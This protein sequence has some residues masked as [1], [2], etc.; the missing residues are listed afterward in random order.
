MA[1]LL[2]DIGATQTRL[3][4]SFDGK[5]VGRKTKSST[6]ENFD[7][8]IR[9]IGERA[10]KLLRGVKIKVV[11]G[12]IAGPL[13][14]DKT[15]VVSEG[16][17][18]GWAYRPLRKNLEELFGVPT[19][20]ENDTALV[21]LGESS[22]GAGMG[23]S[24][25]V[26]VTLSSGFGAT[27][28]VNRNIDT[29]TYGFE[30]AFQVVGYADGEDIGKPHHYLKYHISGNRLKA[31]YGKE[32]K[33]IDDARIWDQIARWVAVSMNNIIVFWSPECIVL[34]GSMARRIHLSHI[35]KYV[36]QAVTVFPTLPDFRRAKLGNYGGLYGAL[37]LATTARYPQAVFLL[38]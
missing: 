30:P 27:R 15:K 1:I 11:A 26:Y 14:I 38:E 4:I 29:S 36:D 12:G 17:I 3:G 31:K 20:L 6:P 13:D 32:P 10:R 33:D 23:Y 5:T 18:P 16:N 28:I 2:F 19:L 21:G 7:C 35:C 8:G 25:V 9:T 22:S 37:K 34:G 24:I